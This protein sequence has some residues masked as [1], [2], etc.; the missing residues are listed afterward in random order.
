MNNPSLIQYAVHVCG[1]PEG[2]RLYNQVSGELLAHVAAHR[3]SFDL[4]Q[5]GLADGDYTLGLSQ[6]D[7]WGSESDRAEIEVS[8]AGGSAAGALLDPRDLRTWPEAGGKVK[9]R[10][11][12][13]TA[14]GSAQRPAEYEIAEAADLSTILATVDGGFVIGEVELGPFAHGST[15]RLR[16]RASDGQAGGERGDWVEAPPVVADTQGPP[17]PALKPSVT[18]PSC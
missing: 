18:D 12:A 8:I 17:V 16:V 11:A 4:D 14:T 1:P 15:Q 3:T 2:F 7:A 5:L 10:F 6:V 9:L 13:W